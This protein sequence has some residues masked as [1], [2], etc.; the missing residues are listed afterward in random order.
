MEDRSGTGARE[1]G[2]RAAAEAIENFMGMF[3]N[4][5]DPPS[6]GGPRSPFRQLRAD[7][8]RAVE[9]NLELVRRAFD[10]YAGA[11]EQVLA[12]DGE[13]TD[14][15]LRLPAVVPGERSSTTLWIHNTTPAVAPPLRPQGSDLHSASGEKIA[16]TS[17]FFEPAQIDR[18]GPGSTYEVAVTVATDATTPAGL[19]RGYVFVPN[20]A[21]EFVS[22][23][24]SVI[25][26]PGNEEAGW[27]QPPPVL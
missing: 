11:V 17:L 4:G 22:L 1:L 13:E 2:F 8:A 19:Y 18:L 20:L 24:L 10:L 27:N 16:S 25:V 23:E 6:P 15:H 9:A 26:P 14:R 21:E 7:L 5:Q 12:T 3:G